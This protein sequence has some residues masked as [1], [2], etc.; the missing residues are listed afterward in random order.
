VGIQV[1]HLV[2]LEALHAYPSDIGLASTTPSPLLAITSAAST[3]IAFAQA[4]SR[5]ATVSGKATVP[6]DGAGTGAMRGRLLSALFRVGDR[7]PI[8]GAGVV[9]AASFYAVP[10]LGRAETVSLSN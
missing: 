7:P 10:S 2:D 3:G 5:Y 4:G 6:P 1:F 9:V 8:P